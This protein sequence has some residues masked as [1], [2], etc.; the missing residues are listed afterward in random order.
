[1]N[2][3]SPTHSLMEKTAISMKAMMI[4][5]RGLVLPRRAP[6]EMSTAAAAKSAVSKLVGD[7]EGI[8]AFEV[9]PEIF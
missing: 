9:D 1:M 5:W 4:S 8:H 3:V 7:G 2:F 6:N